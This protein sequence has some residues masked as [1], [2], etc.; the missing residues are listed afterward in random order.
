VPL[1]GEF[2]LTSVGRRVSSPELVSSKLAVTFGGGGRV[3]EA[4]AL[5]ERKLKSG[6]YAG[7]AEAFRRVAAGAPADPTARFGLWA[8]LVGAED[9]PGAASA[10]RSALEGTGDVGAISLSGRQELL[11]GEA[12]HAACEKLQQRAR[13]RPD[14]PDVGLLLGFHLFT[15]GRYGEAAKALW[16]VYDAD[17]G[18]IAVV[19]LLVAAEDRVRRR[20]RR[21]AAT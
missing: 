5:G 1:E 14:D 9:Y 20:E 17:R 13:E 6:D 18:D 16:P 4:F 21:V 2:G 10:L 12:W 15:V 3:T 7:A 19:K 11:G 8:A